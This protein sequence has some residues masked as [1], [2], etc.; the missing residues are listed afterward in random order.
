MLLFCPRPSSTSTRWS[1]CSWS[2]GTQ[3]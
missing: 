1:S 2:F 3:M